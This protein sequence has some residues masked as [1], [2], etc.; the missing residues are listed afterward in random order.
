MIVNDNKKVMGSF[1]VFSNA[2]TKF[3]CFL[4]TKA[5]GILSFQAKNVGVTLEASKAHCYDP[6]HFHQLKPG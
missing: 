5:A 3:H 4:G 1:L 2:V 6:T